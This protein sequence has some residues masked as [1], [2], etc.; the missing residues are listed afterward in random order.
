MTSSL[1]LRMLRERGKMRKL[2][3]RALEKGCNANVVTARDE[4]ERRD[5]KIERDQRVERGHNAI[6]VVMRDEREEKQES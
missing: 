2:G 3:K 6:V 1:Q 4:R 5:Q